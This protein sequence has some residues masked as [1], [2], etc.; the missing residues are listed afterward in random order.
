VPRLIHLISL[1]AVL[2]I[3]GGCATRA[4]LL[5]VQRDQR[6]VR[7]L[8]AD[9][10]VTVDGLRR[11]VES[12]RSQIDEQQRG[13]RPVGR[14]G[15]RP[16]SEL[17]QRLA[18]LERRLAEQGSAQ[19]L[20]GGALPGEPQVAGLPAPP[21]AEPV[22]PVNPTEAALL[23]EE[24][25][26]QSG[27]DE[28]YREGIRLVRATQCDP[29]AA[30]FRGFLKKSPKSDLADNAQYWI[31][32]CYYGQRDYNKAIIELNEVLLKHPKGD[33]VPSA[34]LTLAMAFA[35]S[36]DRIDARLILQK[37]ISDHPRS[38]EA[39]RGRQKLQALGD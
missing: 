2:A 12:L 20:S 6:E 13:G 30:R 23:Q 15:A 16:T 21:V 10:Q 34:L 29:A 22:R 18:D 33:K 5:R 3:L 38:A 26:T 28:D 27:G 8:L 37:L 36:G 11:R 35:D 24:A 19:P 39:E 14:G 1:V 25:A 31:G 4:D 17:E 7:A 32:E 9:T